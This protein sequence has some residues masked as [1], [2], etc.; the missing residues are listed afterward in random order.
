THHIDLPSGYTGS[1]QVALKLLQGGL[2]DDAPGYVP[3]RHTHSGLTPA[4]TASQA[5]G[6][7]PRITRH[8][9]GE[10]GRGARRFDTTVA[11]PARRPGDYG[12]LMRNWPGFENSDGIR[13]HVIRYLPRD[14]KLFGRLRPGDQYPEAHAA[15]VRMFEEELAAQ[16]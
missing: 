16:K 9:R 5:L 7:L 2:L 10:I 3:A 8:L 1:R 12:Q 14:W 6:D 15:A 11:Y 4:V 13:D